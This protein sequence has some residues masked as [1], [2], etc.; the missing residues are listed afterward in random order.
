MIIYV[1]C[2]ILKS[3]IL[4]YADALKP[5]QPLK[6]PTTLMSPA[7]RDFDCQLGRT[8][9][10]ATNTLSPKFCLCPCKPGTAPSYYH[11]NSNRSLLESFRH[12]RSGDTLHAYRYCSTDKC[13]LSYRISPFCFIIFLGCLEPGYLFGCLPFG[14][15]REHRVRHLRDMT[16]RDNMHRQTFPLFIGEADVILCRNEDPAAA[17]PLR[18]L[19]LCADPTDRKDIALKV[20]FPCVCRIGGNR[21]LEQGRQDAHENRHPR[22]GAV[23]WHR[24]FTE[25]QVQAK[26]LAAQIMGPDV[27]PC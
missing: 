14:K 9:H 17:I 19:N 15:A 5:Y 27:C 24:S 10:T 4:T 21:R 7:G 3:N 25:M 1:L 12:P 11:C 6:K 8:D 23:L 20:D 2:C 18:S 16:D 26:I 13:V 22:R